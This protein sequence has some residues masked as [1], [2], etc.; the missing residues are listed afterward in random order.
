MG[1]G[2]CEAASP[3]RC[4]RGDPCA[5]LGGS[6]ASPSRVIDAALFQTRFPLQLA[7]ADPGVAL[8][9]SLVSPAASLRH[10]WWVQRLTAALT[11]GRASAVRMAHAVAPRSP[12]VLSL[13]VAFL[14]AAVWREPQ[15]L[16]LPVEQFSESSN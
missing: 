11:D 9:P 6:S 10:R 15:P 1:A 13:L 12:S 3:T 2:L 14:S 16:L 8:R 7:S 4:L 5:G